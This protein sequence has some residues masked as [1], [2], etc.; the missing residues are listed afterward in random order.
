QPGGIECP[1][2][3]APPQVFRFT[4]A[5]GSPGAGFSKQGSSEAGAA[6]VVCSHRSSTGA[7]GARRIPR[8]DVAPERSRVVLFKIL[9]GRRRKGTNGRGGTTPQHKYAGHEILRRPRCGRGRLD[10]WE[11]DQCER[12]M[13]VCGRQSRRETG[14]KDWNANAGD[15]RW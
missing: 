2:G 10:G 13:V 15:A 1:G 5:N 7:K 11:R 3:K 8:P 6:F 14:R 4:I 9:A 12:R